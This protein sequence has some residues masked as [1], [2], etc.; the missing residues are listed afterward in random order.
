[1]VFTA[2]AG[3]PTSQALT[4][5]GAV[6][7]RC[8]PACTFI[9]SSDVEICKYLHLTCCDCFVLELLTLKTMIE[10]PIPRIA[11]AHTFIDTSNFVIGWPSFW[12]L[13]WK[14]IPKLASLQSFIAEPGWRPIKAQHHHTT[15]PSPKVSRVKKRTT[16][17]IKGSTGSTHQSQQLSAVGTCCLFSPLLHFHK[18]HLLYISSKCFHI[19]LC[20]FVCTSH[21]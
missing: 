7:R 10:F 6:R 11:D 18:L 1:M 21:D 14:H 5:L 15:P 12:C 19:C 2:I 20:F 8:W 4:G 9:A 16:A 3:Y 13:C 17:M